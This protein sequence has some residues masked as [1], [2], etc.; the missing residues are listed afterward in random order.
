MI[1]TQPSAMI[2]KPAAPAYCGTIA[3]VGH[4]NVG[5]STLMNSILGHKVSITSNKPQTTRLAIRGIKTIANTQY[6]YIDTP[7]LHKNKAEP[8]QKRMT[9]E[10]TNILSQV[11]IIVF[12]LDCT[13]LTTEDRWFLNLF[14]KI[15]VPVVLVINK[16]DLL[17]DK[18][19]LLPIIADAKNMYAFKEIIPLSATEQSN[20]DVLEHML[21]LLLP[22]QEHFF[23]PH[24]Y[25]DYSE[26][27][28]V[29]EIIREQVF[30]QTH[31]EVPYACSVEVEKMEDFPKL[32]RIYVII[33]VT[34][35]GQ[36]K[37]IIGKNGQQLKNI[38]KASRLTL[39]KFFGKKIFLHIFVKIK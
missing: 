26:D 3:L 37:I 35:F 34:R 9:R 22:E 1:S 2:P 20:V 24:Q 21:G 11:D 17:K 25:H 31:R 10:V 7:G 14:E 29:T 12:I 27:F 18:K 32:L 39:E 33:W 8:L 36:K 30:Q 23:P 4:P 13:K 19:Q 38:G 15:S 16:I 28:Y 6:I 5:K